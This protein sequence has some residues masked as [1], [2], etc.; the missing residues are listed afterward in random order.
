MDTT[1]EPFPSRPTLASQLPGY[2]L[3][4]QLSQSTMSAVYLAE[5]TSLGR[6]VAVKVLGSE[7][8]RQDEFRAR[9]KREVWL[10]AKLDHPN[11][12][13]VYAASDSPELCYLAM[14]YVDGHD[15][16]ALLRDEGPLD[17]D[18]TLGLLWQVAGALDAAHRIGL[19]HRDVKPG[20]ILVDPQFGH[21]YLCDF[22]IANAES[23]ETITSTGQ[24]VGTPDYA[25]PEQIKAERVDGRADV[26]A[27]GCVLYHC[28]TGQVP[29]PRTDLP[30]ALWAHLNEPVP[31]VTA[32]RPE[33]STAVDSVL[34]TAMAKNPAER[35]A[36]CAELVGALAV[37]TGRAPAQRQQWGAAEARPV[38]RP[39]SPWAL[40]ALVTVIAVVA[41][42]TLLVVQPWKS[43]PDSVFAL[44]ASRLPAQL[45]DACRASGTG[46]IPGASSTVT[47]RDASG[48]E[49]VLNLFDDQPS[50]DAAYDRVVRAS[51]VA[52]GSGECAEASGGEHRYPSSGTPSGRELCSD[53]GGTST[54]VWTDRGT[55]VVGTANTASADYR[56]LQ[57]AWAGWVEL[58]AF[59]SPE[60]KSLLDLLDEPDCH[61]AA[62]GSLDE[63]APVVAAVDCTPRGTGAR[64]VSYY[65]FASETDLQS[66]YDD[67]ATASGAPTG[68][69]CIDTTPPQGF[70]GNRRFDLRSAELGG[71]LCHPGPQSSLVLEWSVEP[72]LVL[73]RAVGT[74]PEDLTT[75]WNRYYGPPIPAIVD[76][77]NQKAS[78]PFPTPQEQ[79]LLAH[80]PEQ[81]RT[82][83]LRPAPEQVKINVPKGGVTGVVCGPTSGPSI[84][85]YYQ[86]PDAASMAANYDT[87]GRP[88]GP[89]CTTGPP[90]FTGEAPYARDGDTGR[91]LCAT[92]EGDNK[93]MVWTNE[94][95]TI[96]VFAFQGHD[97]AAMA[98]WWRTEAGP[99]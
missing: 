83:C 45:R 52:Q 15:L 99:R 54:I 20:N 2:H 21:V 58:P 49:A 60:E 77:V 47:C 48:R 50:S 39:R 3:I 66:S 25:S 88:S 19:V 62:A 4:R 10:A 87:V 31:R 71:V 95:L 70:L 6:K 93:L 42:V 82:N 13:P 24:F 85:F 64:T 46:G 26:Y 72:L 5:E 23:T 97:A 11:I 61:R 8:S 76:A 59:P 57:Q 33:L 18:R 53:N 51:G 81:S 86:F 98:T 68:V 74:D 37:V 44:G 80:V 34:T 1:S 41:A 89:D 56:A 90:N 29:F 78:P 73:G 38:Q 7:L 35:F 40:A 27:L 36:T 65:R 79:A 14:R 16:R 32:L 12:I 43:E 96:Q 30:A 84:V 94:R 91:L 75:W 55:H 92:N 69:S 28:L 67:H 9:F 63:V 22:G 17:V